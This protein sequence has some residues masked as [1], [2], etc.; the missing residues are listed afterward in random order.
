MLY[1]RRPTWPD[2]PALRDYVI[3]RENLQIGRVYLTKLPEGDRFVWSITSTT[4]FRRC[5]ACRSA[6]R[7]RRSKGPPPRC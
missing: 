1:T 3:R 4:T 7:R 5:R 2:Q 6:A